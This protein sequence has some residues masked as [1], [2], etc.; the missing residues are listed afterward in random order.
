VGGDFYDWQQT[1]PHVLTFT[2]GDVMGKGMP[3]ALLMA[4]VRAALRSVARH[5]PPAETI[6]EAAAALEGDLDRSGSFVTLFHGRLDSAAGRLEYVDA[7]HGHVVVRRADGSVATLPARGLPIGVLPNCTYPQGTVTFAPG[8]ALVVYSDGLLDARPDLSLD[9]ETLA[10]RLDGART[11][12][13]VV[14]RL[15]ALAS[16]TGPPPDDLTVVALCCRPVEAQP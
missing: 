6:R 8:D 3:A 13:E 2:V 14:E 7:G 15:F 10:A 4:T 5:S 9:V 1:A 16:L 11:A 12:A